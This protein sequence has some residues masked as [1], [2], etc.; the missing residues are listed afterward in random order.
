MRD[1]ARSGL[2]ILLVTHH[3]SEII[4]EIDRVILLRA[5][6][7]LADGPKDKV[8]TEENLRALFGVHVRLQKSDGYVHLY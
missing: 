8:L 6:R 5:G 3:V 4:P 2:A 7:I 1:L